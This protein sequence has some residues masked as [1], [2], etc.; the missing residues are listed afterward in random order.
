MSADFQKL[1]AEKARFFAESLDK[2][3]IIHKK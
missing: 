1:Q 2:E 3:E